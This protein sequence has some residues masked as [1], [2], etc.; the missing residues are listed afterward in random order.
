V[1]CRSRGHLINRTRALIV[2]Q[3]CDQSRC[4]CKKGNLDLRMS[5]MTRCASASCTFANMNT[6]TD[7]DTLSVV[8]IQYCADRGFSPEGMTIPSTVEASPTGSN[9]PDAS[10]TGTEAVQTGTGS[11][12]DLNSGPSATSV[13]ELMTSTILPSKAHLHSARCPSFWGVCALCL[14]LIRTCHFF[15]YC[16]FPIAIIWYTR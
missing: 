7:L 10:A 3:G 15:Y 9:S 13:G 8:Q 11:R 12:T 5:L 1:E 14:T 4:W 6:Q 2:P 16:Q